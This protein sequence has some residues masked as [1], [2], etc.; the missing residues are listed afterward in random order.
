MEFYAKLRWAVQTSDAWRR[1][2][3]RA[4]SCP[5]VARLECVNPKTQAT[6]CEARTSSR[7]GSWFLAGQ[8]RS[9]RAILLLENL[10]QGFSQMR[11]LDL[12]MGAETSVACWKGRLAPS[13]E[14]LNG[15]VWGEG[16]SERCFE[17]IY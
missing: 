6:G 2:G 4:M 12:K 14:T 8:E 5:G 13:F 11:L 15:S 10:R 3:Q 7:G 1:F 17:L 16:S 9:R